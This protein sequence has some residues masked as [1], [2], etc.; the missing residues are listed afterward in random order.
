MQL[1][2]PGNITC[3]DNSSH[4]PSKPFQKESICQVNFL[5]HNM[6]QIQDALILHVKLLE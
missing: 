3:V 5:L 6:L 1:I 4:I 2:A